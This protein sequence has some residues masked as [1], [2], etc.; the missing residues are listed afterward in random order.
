MIFLLFLLVKSL[1]LQSFLSKQRKENWPMNRKIRKIQVLVYELK[2]FF[3][4]NLS[5]I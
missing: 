4:I 2:C 1:L 5:I 3:R